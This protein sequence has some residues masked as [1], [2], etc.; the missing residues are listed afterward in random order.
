MSSLLARTRDTKAS[1]VLLIL[2]LL[3][4]WE[5]LISG[6]I[7][8]TV[9]VPPFSSV[10]QTWWELLVGGELFIQL[11]ATLR[12]MAIGYAI[13]AVVGISIGLIMG[14][15]RPVYNLLE[16]ITEVLRPMPS[17]AYI[18][19]VILFLGLKDS[20]KI[21][22]IFFAC[23]WPIL[24]NTY[25]GVRSV[26]PVQLATARTFGLNSRQMIR[27]VV[28]PASAPHVFTGLRIS[29][30]LALILA[31]IAEMIASN[32]GIGHFILFSQRSFRIKEMYAGVI[33][34]GIVGYSLN[35]LFLALEARLLAWHKGSSG[36]AANA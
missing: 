35:W 12:R 32:D 26:E 36:R 21:F 8:E 16:P 30:G 5:L 18:P 15:Y 3:G 10:V 14:Y 27:K 9:S 1:G 11:W 31:I 4:L 17:P 33:T 28:I 23:L 34:L 22:V 19:I 13:A 29:L 20:M 24:L 25:S 6:G 2:G 7:V